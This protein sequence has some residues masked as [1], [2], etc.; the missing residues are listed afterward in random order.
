MMAEAESEFVSQ[1]SFDG[2]LDDAAQ[3]FFNLA[4]GEPAAIATPEP[5][6]A[7]ESE[8]VAEA[9]ADE[10]VEQQE[11]GPEAEEVAAGEGEEQSFV[12][13]MVD[14]RA[15]EVPLNELIAGYHR[16]SDYTRKAQELGED[17]R[18]VEAYAQSVTQDQ[19]AAAE[20][21]NEVAQQLQAELAN[22]KEDPREL[23]ALRVQNPGEY[24]ARM[25]D[26][27]R[28][29]QMLQMA[30]QEQNALNQ[31][32]RQEQI[33]RAISELQSMEPA[34]AKDF[35]ATYEQVGRWITSPTGGGLSAENWNQVVDPRQVLI[36]YKAMLADEQG[37]TVREATPRIRKKLSTMPNVRAG[38]PVDPG[39]REQ[40]VFNES[41]NAMKTDSS[42][43][44]I[45]NA[46]L[47]REQLNKTR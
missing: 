11:P 18:K 42:L 6:A 33:P 16:E 19:A 45:A 44:A 7:E 21:M 37:M 12:E 20:R 27:Q 36:A 24:A 3:G 14:G 13:V 29:D 15:T 40:S 2:A 26:N 17:R 41:V 32:A 34:F 43:D 22:H 30:Y 25:Q 47:R 10:V 4:K 35:D 1:K 31:Q 28:R 38:V 23:E 46:F 39:Q 5:Q 8:P 9:Q